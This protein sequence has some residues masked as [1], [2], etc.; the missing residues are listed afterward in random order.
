MKIT[1]NV[2]ETGEPNENTIDVVP[3][4]DAKAWLDILV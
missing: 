2:H 1:Q 3:I 4:Y